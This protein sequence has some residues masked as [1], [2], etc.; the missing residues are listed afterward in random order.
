MSAITARVRRFLQKPGTA[1]LSKYQRLLPAIAALEDDLRDVPD[2]DLAGLAKEAKDLPA[3]CAVGREAGRQRA[4]EG[5]ALTS[6]HLDHV[7]GE[8]AQGP[9]Q[10]HVKWTER[11]RPL[12]RFP[13]DR[14]ELRDVGGLREIVEVE[15]PSRLAQLLVAKTGGFLVVFRGG[16]DLGEGA[17]SILFRAGAQ[18]SPKSATH[19]ARLSPDGL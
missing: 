16:G 11:G 7:A 8:H 17:G 18:Q 12:A 10:L 5:L 15:Q 2:E 6:G 9:E 14:E 1:D 13:G 19:A 4:S 3:F